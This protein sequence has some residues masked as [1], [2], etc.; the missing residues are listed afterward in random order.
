MQS[1]HKN[2]NNA[3]CVFVEKYQCFVEAHDRRRVRANLCPRHD[4]RPSRRVLESW[5]LSS[6]CPRCNFSSDCRKS[7]GLLVR[8]VKE[9]MVRTS[10]GDC[11]STVSHASLFRSNAPKL[12]G[13]DQ[14]QTVLLVPNT[15]CANSDTRLE[16]VRASECHCTWVPMS[17]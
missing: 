2:Q 4:L 10:S 17:S 3:S 14:S 15:H 5:Q 9:M 16:V 12:R 8:V 7:I 13:C 11:R 1:F 6:R